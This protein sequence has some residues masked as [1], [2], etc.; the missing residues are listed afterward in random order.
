MYIPIHQF[1]LFYRHRTVETVCYNT[2]LAKFERIIHAW[3]MVYEV[4]MSTSFFSMVLMQESTSLSTSA[5]SEVETGR[6]L[7][8][9]AP[10]V[11]AGRWRPRK[12]LLPPG[13]CTLC[14]QH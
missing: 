5:S 4:W 14:Q 13:P 11:I 1:S 10:A 9:G 6:D 12:D 7:Y 8:I 2:V 3:L